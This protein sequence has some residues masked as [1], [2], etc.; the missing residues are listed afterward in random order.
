MLRCRY[1]SAGD[2]VA[3]GAKRNVTAKESLH[4]LAVPEFD[5][6]RACQS[7]GALE[8]I[9]RRDDDAEIGLEVLGGGN[10]FLN[11]F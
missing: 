5:V 8:E 4:S 11:G 9:V 2:R 7:D 10:D 1:L 6:I 3:Q